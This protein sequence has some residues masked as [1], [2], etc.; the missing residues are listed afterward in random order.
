MCDP[1]THLNGM[2]RPRESP[3]ARPGACES[4]AR[5]Q[6]DWVVNRRER[7]ERW[8]RGRWSLRCVGLVGIW[9]IRRVRLIRLRRVRLRFRYRLSPRRDKGHAG[10]WA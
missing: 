8:R 4:A 7:V 6:R 5:R 2:T 10:S 1:A 9:L 3:Q